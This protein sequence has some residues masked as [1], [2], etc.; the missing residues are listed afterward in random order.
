MYHLNSD[1]MHIT[2]S[3]AQLCRKLG[4][5]AE[6]T[7]VNQCSG[8][9]VVTLGFEPGTLHMLGKCCA[10]E[11]N[12]HVPWSFDA[13]S[14]YVAQAG[15]EPTMLLPQQVPPNNEVTSL[16][17]TTQLEPAGLKSLPCLPLKHRERKTGL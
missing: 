1:G 6:T 13:G 15:L 12:L 2:S 10:T 16:Y 8:F 5:K 4:Q 3:Q 14:R 7:G 17:R 9:L 11:L